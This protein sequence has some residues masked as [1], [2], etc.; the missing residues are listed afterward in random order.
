MYSGP[1]LTHSCVPLTYTGFSI[2]GELLSLDTVTLSSE[3]SVSAGV[4]ATSIS[5]RTRVKVYRGMIGV[6]VG[7]R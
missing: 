3:R 2:V 4:T 1:P 5:L 7:E 6:N